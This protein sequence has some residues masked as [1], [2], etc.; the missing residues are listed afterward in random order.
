MVLVGTLPSAV[1]APVEVAV[2]WWCRSAT[3]QPVSP[4]SLWSVVTETV[5]CV[6]STTT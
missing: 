1:H 6:L 3:L 2:R 5:P 4:V